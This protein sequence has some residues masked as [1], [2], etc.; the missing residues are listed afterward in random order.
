MRRTRIIE[1]SVFVVLGGRDLLAPDH[2]ALL[3]LDDR[4]LVSLAD[5]CA[6]VIIVF[7]IVVV[8]LLLEMWDSFL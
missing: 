7:V 8:M 4:K 5:C 2:E 3:R 1:Q 6:F